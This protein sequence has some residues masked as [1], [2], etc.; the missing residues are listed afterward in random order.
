MRKRLTLFIGIAMLLGISSAQP[1]TPAGKPIDLYVL[2]FD[3]VESDSEI[4]WL[5]DGFIDFI[6]NHYSIGDEVIV[7]CTEK[8]DAVVKQIR[9]KTLEPGKKYYVLT[10]SFHR[11]NGHFLVDLELFDITNWQKINSQQVNQETVDIARI[12]EEVNNALDEMLIPDHKK[13]AVEPWMVPTTKSVSVKN[14]SVRAESHA[15]LEQKFSAISQTTLNIQ[16]VLDNFDK[17]L[18]NDPQHSIPDENVSATRGVFEYKIREHLTQ[19]DT[20]TELLEKI[21]HDPYQI[22]IKSPVFQRISGKEDWVEMSFSVSF[23]PKRELIRE[24]FVTLPVSSIF[25]SP[26]F[27]EFWFKGDKFVIDEKI[28]RRIALGEFRMF[29]V[30]SFIR[31]NGNIEHVIIDVPATSGFKPKSETYDVQHSFS[32]LLTVL[33]SSWDV[34]VFLLKR[35]VAIDY[36]IELPIKTLGDLA[37]ISVRM[38]SEEEISAYLKELR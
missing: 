35:D 11:T 4:G 31:Q 2:S 22:E 32:P 19:S 26:D 3:N 15:T 6:S 25:E 1:S 27:S 9:E 23:K 16:K 38:M 36:S 34:K 20:F 21:T 29:P 18:H 12:I 30:V 7:H 24:M 14:D 8:M 37:T 33:G 13:N 10:G 17:T 5:K 28:T